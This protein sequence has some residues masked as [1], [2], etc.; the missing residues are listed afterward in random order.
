MTMLRDDFKLKSSFFTIEESNGTVILHGHGYGHGVGLCQEGAIE[1][2]KVG[3]TY[4]DILMFYFHGVTLA[5][6]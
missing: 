1:M 3:Y 2:A 6:R 5:D 4:L